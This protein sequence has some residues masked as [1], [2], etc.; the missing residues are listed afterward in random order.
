MFNMLGAGRQKL[1]LPTSNIHCH[2]ARKHFVSYLACLA[3]PSVRSTTSS[4]H[5]T[6]SLRL[7]THSSSHQV[8]SHMGLAPT[9]SWGGTFLIRAHNIVQCHGLGSSHREEMAL[10]SMVIFNFMVG[11]FH[12]GATA[13]AWA[14]LSLYCGSPCSCTSSVTYFVFKEAIVVGPQC[15]SLVCP[16]KIR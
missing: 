12:A 5:G 9:A 11:V 8:V 14:L 16:W 4:H 7:S 6:S 10:G 13:A 2:A 1:A 15:S 3:P